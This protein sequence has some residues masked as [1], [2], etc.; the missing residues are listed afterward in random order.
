MSGALLSNG[1][2]DAGST[3]FPSRDDRTSL[4]SSSLS[5]VGEDLEAPGTSSAAEEI[6]DEDSEAETERLDQTP[7]N[8]RTVG[9]TAT[10][11]EAVAGRSPSKLGREIP[12]EH[13]SSA[14]ASPDTMSNRD[15][16]PEEDFDEGSINPIAKQLPFGDYN[17]GI[18]DNE[19][20]AKK[21]KRLSPGDDVSTDEADEPA[22]KR[23]GSSKGHVLNGREEEDETLVDNSLIIR[24]DADR[25][26]QADLEEDVNDEIPDENDEI[27]EPLPIPEK[28]SHKKQP[29][30]KRKGKKIRDEDAEQLMQTLEHREG[31][32]D[33]IADEEADEDGSTA[34]EE[35][36]RRGIAKEK[37]SEIEK[38]FTAFRS[39]LLEERIAAFTNELELL[40]QPN[41]T[42]PALSEQTRCVDIR[43]DEKIQREADLL[44]LKTKELIRK[45]LADR[46]Q[47]Q[48]QYFQTVREARDRALDAC[49]YRLNRL[50]RERRHWGAD[51]PDYA[52]MYHPD[53]AVQI[54]YQQAYNNEVSILAGVQKYVGFPAAPEIL[55]TKAT[56][57]EDDFRAMKVSRSFVLPYNQPAVS[58]NAKN[59]IDLPTTSYYS[60]PLRIPGG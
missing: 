18:D 44:E 34:D 16:T 56:E 10:I 8:L 39:R 49:N 12:Y 3:T 1:A 46:C 59:L 11:V 53:R 38:H 41:S 54:R 33:E 25:L 17:R 20:N 26:A 5:D 50:Q 52:F 32:I 58:A 9:A 21:R 60:P 55:G 47:Y 29:K 51:E 19:F 7:R 43:R 4:R 13:E 15:H 45:T 36:A 22:R 14:I 27:K 40:N 2:L 24:E 42:H 31:E 28:K 37:L 57:A 48:S 23:S 35:R 30:G 6:G